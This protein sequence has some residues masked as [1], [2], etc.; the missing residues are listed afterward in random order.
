MSFG[1]KKYLE[2]IRNKYELDENDNLVNPNPCFFLLK[3]SKQDQKMNRYKLNPGEQVKIGRI[4]M[5]IR[6]IKFNNKSVKNSLNELLPKSQVKNDKLKENEKKLKKAHNNNTRLETTDKLINDN[7][8]NKINVFVTLKKKKT[9][10]KILQYNHVPVLA[11]LNL[12][13]LTV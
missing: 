7:K 5:R 10:K 6:D 13:I 9:T 12:F 4:T 2:I 3:P 11:Q 1:K 8:N